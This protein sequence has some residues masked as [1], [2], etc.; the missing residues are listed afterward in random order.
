M[1]TF[2][3][4][5]MLYFT[6]HVDGAVRIRQFS[7]ERHAEVM[8]R[9][10]ECGFPDDD[11]DNADVLDV[12]IPGCEWVSIVATMSALNNSDVGAAY[13]LTESL[14]NPLTKSMAGR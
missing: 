1:S 8:S 12:T 7:S 11:G 4:R 9:P 6:R 14:H 2:H 13:R 3:L 5:G 10:H